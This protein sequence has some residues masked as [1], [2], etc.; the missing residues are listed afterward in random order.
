[1][2]VWHSIEMPHD[3]VDPPEP[4]LPGALLAGQIREIPGWR[5]PVENSPGWRR[6]MTIAPPCSITGNI[7]GDDTTRDRQQRDRLT[8][9]R[10]GD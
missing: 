8:A 9:A 6:G 10:S 7:T 2:V 3:W 4:S 1:M 5:R